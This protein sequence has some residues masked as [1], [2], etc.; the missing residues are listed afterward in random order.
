MMLIDLKK[1]YDS[2]PRSALWSILVKCGVLPIMLNIIKSFHEGMEVS[3]R[4]GGTFTG[5]IEVR[6]GLRQGCT[7]STFTLM[8]WCLRGVS[9]VVRSVSLC[10]TSLVEN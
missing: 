10:C 1:A 9:G 3:V 7:T 5:S 4:V 8:Q 6:N 2:V